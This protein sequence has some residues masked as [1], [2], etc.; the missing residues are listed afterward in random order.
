MSTTIK[1]KSGHNVVW[2][3]L[4]SLDDG[5]LFDRPDT[6][7]NIQYDYRVERGY[8]PHVIG[9]DEDMVVNLIF[10]NDTVH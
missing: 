7:F 5:I 10:G 3:L 4:G 1:R 8:E 6:P 2:F 9:L